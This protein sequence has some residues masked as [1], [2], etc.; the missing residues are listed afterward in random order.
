ML[1][2]NEFTYE[3]NRALIFKKPDPIPVEAL[4]RCVAASLTYHRNKRGKAR[5]AHRRIRVVD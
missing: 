3:G 1:F 5:S 2:P 4:R